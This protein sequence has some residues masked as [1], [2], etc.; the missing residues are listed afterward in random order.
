M[1]N[2]LPATHQWHWGCTRC[3]SR[4][5]LGFTW[6]THLPWLDAH[7]GHNDADALDAQRTLLCRHCQREPSK[8]Q[9]L[10]AARTIRT[11]PQPSWSECKSSW[12]P[13][14]GE[15][16]Q[17]WS[18]AAQW[19]TPRSSSLWSWTTHSSLFRALGL[20]QYH[21]FWS[22]AINGSTKRCCGWLPLLWSTFDWSAPCGGGHSFA[23]GWRHPW[24]LAWQTCPCWHHLLGTQRRPTS[25]T[26]RSPTFAA[27]FRE[28]WPF[29]RA[30]HS[31]AMWSKGLSMHYPSQQPALAWG[32]FGFKAIEACCLCP[33]GNPAYDWMSFTWTSTTYKTGTRA[34]IDCRRSSWHYQRHGSVPNR[35]ENWVQTT[36][37]TECHISKP[38][39]S[40]STTTKP[41]RLWDTSGPNTW[42]SL[43]PTSKHGL[44][45]VCHHW[46]SRRRTS[47]LLDDMV[48]ASSE[49]HEKLR[50]KTTASG[51]SST[52]VV[53]RSLCGLVG[54]HGSIPTWTSSPCPPRTS[55]R[56][57][58]SLRRTS[59]SRTRTWRSFADPLDRSFRP[60]HGT[61]AL[62][63][64]WL[65]EALHHT[66]W[67]FR[68]AGH[69]QMVH[70]KSLHS[71]K[72]RH[73][74]SWRGTYTN[75]SRREHCGH[76]RQQTG[77]NRRGDFA[78]ATWSTGAPWR[79]R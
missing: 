21:P 18:C 54:C 19:T 56:W 60:P 51:W 61:A 78:H 13:W 77:C 49:I 38:T 72:R 15:P 9:Q 69:K 23:K 70:I 41:C 20:L 7:P 71:E 75:R 73:H 24:R 31:G 55:C 63:L 36:S 5:L 22:L 3:W 47:H 53:S 8:C 50:V 65:D 44:C 16:H 45:P 34:D 32:W 48:S 17:W 35:P 6:I 27:V 33:S 42:A 52:F 40:S 28:D 1:G 39:S 43:A 10:C 37:N 76:D 11:Q 58:S 79:T 59:H 62:A 46:T 64:C 57:S 14:R 74:I 4:T 25:S 68:G 26:E 30:W 67:S 12:S 66:P 2:I 29:T